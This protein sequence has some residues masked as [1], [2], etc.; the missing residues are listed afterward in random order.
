METSPGHIPVS[1]VSWSPQANYVISG[2]AADSNLIVW[3]V[4]MGVATR[5]RRTEGGG[6]NLVCVSPTGRRVFA[7]SVGNV[8]RVWETAMWTCEKWTNSSGR[9]QAACWS[10]DGEFL[11]FALRG[12][13]ALYYLGF[14][15]SN[16]A[17]THTLNLYNCSAC[18]LSI[19]T[20]NSIDC[21]L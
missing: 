7:A 11:L 18:A 16:T 1:S 6:V 21:M 5:V 13:H 17:G 2:S 9:C 10:P 12:D 14:H 19:H 20:L 15:G 8:M 4:P 3:D